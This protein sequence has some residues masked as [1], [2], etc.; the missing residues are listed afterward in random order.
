[1]SVSKVFFFSS[2]LI[3]YYK[4]SKSYSHCSP[5]CDFFNLHAQLLKAY[6]RQRVT[7]SNVSLLNP[8]ALL[9]LINS[10]FIN[11]CLLLSKRFH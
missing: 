8:A 9:I 2:K 5:L 4:Q 1:L 10:A 11:S 7:I 6:L 3:Q